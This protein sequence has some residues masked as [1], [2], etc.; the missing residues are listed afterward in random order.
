MPQP[1][2]PKKLKLTGSTDL[3]ELTP[4]KDS[5]HHRGLECKS[6]KSRDTWS[7]RQVW[8]WSTNESGLRLTVLPREHTVHNTLIQQ[9]NNRLYTWTPPDGQYQNQT[10]YI[11]CSQRLRKYT[12]SAKTRPGADCGSD[13]VLLIAKLR[14]KWK[15]VR[16]TTRPIR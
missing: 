6:R 8:S 13:H 10:D 14:L 11:I 3:L 12:Q 4:K 15:R 2:M 5:F 7:N 16:K 9:H 1:L